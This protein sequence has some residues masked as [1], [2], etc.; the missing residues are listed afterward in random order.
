M[1]HSPPYY[2]EAHGCFSGLGSAASG[3]VWGILLKSHSSKVKA[4]GEGCAQ[5]EQAGNSG[6]HSFSIPT[7]FRFVKARHPCPAPRLPI[8]SQ[9]VRGS[10]KKTGEPLPSRTTACLA[11][12]GGRHQPSQTPPMGGPQV[13]V[14]LGVCGVCD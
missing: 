14:P 1:C 7:A 5:R 4:P 9:M 2:C 13:L 10:L 6:G 12:G 3:V 11:M 8:G